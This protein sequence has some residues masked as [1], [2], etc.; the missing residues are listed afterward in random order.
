MLIDFLGHSL[1][2]PIIL[3]LTA[4]AAAPLVS[5]KGIVLILNVIAFF[6]CESLEKGITLSPHLMEPDV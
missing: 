6:K 4:G 2:G 5:A 1:F 3:F